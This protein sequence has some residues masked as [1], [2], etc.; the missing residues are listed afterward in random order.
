MVSSFR[1]GGF[2]DSLV[3]S[4]VEGLLLCIK[5]KKSER[6]VRYLKKRLTGQILILYKKF[7]IAWFQY[8]KFE[9]TRVT[10][11]IDESMSRIRKKGP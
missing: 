4:R 11:S 1:K 3:L 5:T 2:L 8:Y 10:E 9:R 6:R 7:N